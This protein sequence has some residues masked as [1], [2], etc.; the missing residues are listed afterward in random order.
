MNWP[1]RSSSAGATAVGEN[2]A[3]GIQ[4]GV[5]VA[6]RFAEHQCPG[7]LERPADH[8]AARHL[9]QAGIV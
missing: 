4:H 2:R 8:F 1:S 7:V 9:A 6:Q 5:V 3:H